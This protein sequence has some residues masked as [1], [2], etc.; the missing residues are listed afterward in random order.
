MMKITEEWKAFTR[1]QRIVLSIYT[2]FSLPLMPFYVVMIPFAFW[3][4][5]SKDD[6]RTLTLIEFLSMAMAM[7]VFAYPVALLIYC[8]GPK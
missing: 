6:T 7:S 4:T 2:L 1:Y 5:R 8:S 3:V